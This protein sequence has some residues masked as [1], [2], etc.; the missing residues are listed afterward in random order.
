[1]LLPQD[2]Q[3]QSQSIVVVLPLPSQYALQYLLPASAGQ[4][5]LAFA[6][7]LFSSAISRFSFRWLDVCRSV[8]WLF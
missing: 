7:F 8:R 4:V 6:H 1:M 2:G 3:P 5:Q